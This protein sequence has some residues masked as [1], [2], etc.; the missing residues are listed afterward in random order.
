[1]FYI[2]FVLAVLGIY[3][4]F[5]YKGCRTKKLETLYGKELVDYKK[6]NPKGKVFFKAW[7]YTSVLIGIFLAWP[8]V[9]KQSLSIIPCVRKG[10]RGISAEV[11]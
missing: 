9:I 1:M 8:T 3:T 2:F 4:H 11:G 6:N 5:I 7:S 10:I